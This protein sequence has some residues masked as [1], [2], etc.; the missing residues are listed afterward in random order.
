MLRG[1]IEMGVV[2]FDVTLF[3]YLGTMLNGLFVDGI[4]VSS[5]SFLQH[6]LRAIHTTLESVFFYARQMNT[7][8]FHLFEEMHCPDR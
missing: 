7:N 6:S 4:E 8:M 1:R 5:M 2:L 3:I